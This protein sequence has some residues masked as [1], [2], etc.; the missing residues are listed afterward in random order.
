MSNPKSPSNNKEEIRN[1]W[2]LNF[3][4]PLQVLTLVKVK[5]KV[6]EHQRSTSNRLEEMTILWELT[7]MALLVC[8]QYSY[9]IVLT[10]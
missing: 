6:P 9:R 10:V 5:S 3:L 2:Y 7:Y 4:K 1:L 8:Q